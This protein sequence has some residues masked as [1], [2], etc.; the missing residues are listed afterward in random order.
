MQS[1]SRLIYP[2]FSLEIPDK[3]IKKI[4]QDNF[5]FIWKNKYHYIRKS[6]IVKSAEDGGLNVID[7]DPMNGTI[8]LKWL[9]HFIR[10]GHSF[11]FDFPSKIFRNFG[12]ID[13]LLRCDFDIS[14]L[15][16][17]L[18]AFHRQAL[19]YWKL[20]YKHNFTPH[21]VPIWNNRC[22][23]IRRKSFFYK[24]WMEKG[25]WSICHLLDNNGDILTYNSFIVKYNLVCTE[26]QYKV[27]IKA[28]PQA[29]IL[30]TKGMLTYSVIIPQEPS[31]FIEGETFPD[32]K[33][34][35]KFIRTALNSIC[36]PSPLKRKHIFQKFTKN[37]IK[38]IRTNYLSFPVPPKVKEVHFKMLYEIYPCNDF[39]NQRFN[40]DLNVCT[41]CNSDIETVEH[42]FFLCNAT[43]T[44]WNRFQYW[45]SYNEKDIP[46]LTYEKIRFGI[47]MEN[48]ETQFGNNNLIL[49]ANYFIHKC[50]FLKT[51]PVFV[52][53]YNELVLYKKTIKLCKMKGAQLFSEYLCA[54]IPD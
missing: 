32:K 10:E 36:F 22:I 21:T 38:K 51:S 52:A 12:N 50:R 31:L 37:D 19:L 48:K 28:I 18:S 35:N 27:V 2:A 43:Q 7:F 53:F 54:L 5:N 16:V 49:L 41:F 26:K 25:I 23:L 42:L 33:C 14:K 46:I 3:L 9:Q 8:K 30:L 13:F 39:L 6:D 24:E 4:N 40:L 47:K 1:L 45:I 29:M 17:K 20:I 15:P 34:N 44:F 11:W